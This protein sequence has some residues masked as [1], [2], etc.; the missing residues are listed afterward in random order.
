MQRMAL[1][2]AANSDKAIGN[3]AHKRLLPS[4]PSLPTS[5]EASG[6]PACLEVLM[7]ERHPTVLARMQKSP[8][9]RCQM[10]LRHTVGAQAVGKLATLR[11][12][13]IWQGS[14]INPAVI[15]NQAVIFRDFSL[16]NIFMIH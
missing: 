1:R 12:E 14:S 13:N 7:V 10:S 4:S 3:Y 9:Q 8:W 16:V 2:E 11:A 5:Q 6:F 15:D